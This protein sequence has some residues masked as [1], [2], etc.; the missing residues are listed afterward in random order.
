M[1]TG[2]NGCWGKVET[3]GEKLTLIWS[4]S[5]H[6]FRNNPG[7]RGNFQNI[8]YSDQALSSV[9]RLNTIK[10]V[11]R[12]WMWHKTWFPFS[13]VWKDN[14]IVSFYKNTAA[15]IFSYIAILFTNLCTEVKWLH[16][17]LF[18]EF[19]LLKSRLQENSF[20]CLVIFKVKIRHNLKCLW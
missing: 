5:S 11:W 8:V 12:K 20:E 1:L 2:Y 13:V 6:W 19:R 9:F 17:F 10:C 15:K 14:P 4:Q 3:W 18:S 7:I 16:W